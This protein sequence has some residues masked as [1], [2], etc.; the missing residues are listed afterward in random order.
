MNKIKLKTYNHLGGKMKLK[1]ILT[2]IFLLL[3]CV[4]CDLKIHS[5]INISDLLSG[6]NKIVL[7]DLK[8]EVPSCDGES[9]QEVI[10]EVKNRKIAAKYNSCQSEDLSSFAVFSLPVPLVKQG[11]IPQDNSDIYLSV[12]NNTL[13]IHSLE[14]VRRVFQSARGEQLDIKE[15]VFDLV[16]DTDQKQKIQTKYVFVDGKPVLDSSIDIM[17]Y[18]K[19]TIKLS[20]VAARSLKTPQ[21]TCPVLEF[22]KD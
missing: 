11:H 2:L 22:L 17:P 10:N 21:T 16:N 14:S 5:I 18:S 7:M 4:A 20:D 13:Y 6:S 9:L 1:K 3:V 12:A 15:I 8:L 19:A